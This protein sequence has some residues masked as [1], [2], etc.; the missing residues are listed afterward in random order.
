V[1]LG[2]PG[3]LWL[4]HRLGEGPLTRALAAGLLLISLR[5]AWGA[6]RS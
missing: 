3:G 4:N 1:L 5:T 2:N 6:L